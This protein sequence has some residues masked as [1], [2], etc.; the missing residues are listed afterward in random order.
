MTDATTLVQ[1]NASAG[2]VR[3]ETPFGTVDAGGLLLTQGEGKGARL[4]FNR[5]VRLL[6]LPE[7]PPP[8]EAP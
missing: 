2:A 4:V 3:A 7:R 1:Q 8:A 6:Y 5:G